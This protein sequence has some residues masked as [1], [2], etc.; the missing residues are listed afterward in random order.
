VRP[1]REG[2]QPTL[3]IAA[4]PP[5]ERRAAHPIGDGRLADVQAVSDDGQDCVVSLFHFADLHEHSAH[6][7]AL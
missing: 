7:L 6:L 2:G 1:L 3:F 4:H 5:I